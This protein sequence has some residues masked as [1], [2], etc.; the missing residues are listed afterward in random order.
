MKKLT[1]L[2][3]VIVS[4]FSSVLYAQEKSV[5]TRERPIICTSIGFLRGGGGLIG[6]D[7][8][9][10]VLNHFGIQWGVGYYT[11][12]ISHCMGSLGQFGEQCERTGIFQQ[13]SP[14]QTVGSPCLASFW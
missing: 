9:Y 10:V 1:I 6:I 11:V 13:H 3:I 14:C 12:T 8:E 4:T 2:I 5:A 7:I